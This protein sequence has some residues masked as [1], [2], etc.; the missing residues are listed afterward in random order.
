LK[1]AWDDGFRLGR[2]CGKAD[3]LL[4]E[5]KKMAMKLGIDLP[6]EDAA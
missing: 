3:A 5:V 4:N 1:A 6:T 2:L